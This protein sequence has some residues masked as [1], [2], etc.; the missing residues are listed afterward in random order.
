VFA[1]D[2]ILVKHSE[3]YEAENEERLD[4]ARDGRSE[5]DGDDPA[6]P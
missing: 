4:D 5:D 1:S 6:D 2:R 3:E